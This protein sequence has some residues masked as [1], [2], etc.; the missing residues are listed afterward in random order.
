M[1]NRTHC[2]VSM[3]TLRI[4]LSLFS[5]RN[6]LWRSGS[7]DM[8]VKGGHCVFWK[9]EGFARASRKLNGCLKRATKSLKQ[10]GQHTHQ[11]NKPVCKDPN[12]PVLHYTFISHIV[13]LLAFC[14]AVPADTTTTITTT[15]TTVHAINYKP[16][17]VTHD[18][19]EFGSP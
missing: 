12:M 16:L 18:S 7:N 15:T 19:K 3:A 9:R 5:L 11:V 6:L 1:K 13:A 8:C 17:L 10:L 2:C 4:S 14:T